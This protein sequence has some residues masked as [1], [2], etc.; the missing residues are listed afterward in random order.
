MVYQFVSGWQIRERP[1]K[2]NPGQSQQEHLH[3][4]T[5]AS[6]KHYEKNRT[7]VYACEALNTLSRLHLDAIATLGSE[8]IDS[9][10][11]STCW[12]SEREKHRR[13]E[14]E[15][16]KKKK[17]KKEEEERWREKEED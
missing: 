12:G 7:R 8:G 3:S 6:Q 16:K 11:T 2:M 5:K 15:E 13:E 9:L 4:H 17:K 14:E 10:A 1:D